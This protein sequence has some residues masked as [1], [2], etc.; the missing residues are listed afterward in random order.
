[1]KKSILFSLALVFT[2]AS[3]AQLQNFKVPAELQHDGSQKADWHG[4]SSTTGL[5]VVNPGYQYA[6]RIAAGELTAS[7][8]ITHVKFYSDH[9]NYIGYGLTN[10]SYTIKI[11]E[12]GSFDEVNGYDVITA[13]GT[14]MHSQAYTA[15]TSGIQEVE[16]TTA[17][18]I[19]AGEFWVAILCNGTSGVFTGDVDP[20]S[21][22]IYVMTYDNAGTDIWV[23]NEFCLDPPTC[24]SM[25]Y[26]PFTLAVYVDDG[27]TYI[28]NS[29]M[30]C[31]FL[32]DG[33]A[34]YGDIITE[35][36]ITG[37]EDLVIY[38]AVQNNGPDASTSASNVLV[39]VAGTEY[40]NTNADLT[41][42]SGFF[43]FL[44][45]DPYSVTITA[46]ELDAAGATGTFNVCLTTTYSGVD[47]VAGNNQACLAVTRGAT[48]IE[49][50]AIG[51][52]SLYPNPANNIINI[53]NADNQN[54]TIINMVGETVAT[55]EN[56]S[57]NQTIDVSNLS[58]GTYFVK[59]DSQTIKM[60]VIK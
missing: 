43:T 54:I 53:S 32:A 47:N 57:A 39:E 26:K 2:I 46:A 14:E 13:N 15:T 51:Q 30:T 23:N 34:P 50:N 40:L 52:I 4:N 44:A 5:S 59:V 29:D 31:F 45:P 21:A 25:G 35:V 60:N 22:N 33:I 20:A 27:G 8:E 36:E 3:F 56:A 11:Y 18:T 12:G 6:I 16:L 41:L 58:E 37:T 55:I 42:E 9:E 49:E 17:Y 28:E 19:G 48:N 10:T 1:M 24:S 38:P 7:D